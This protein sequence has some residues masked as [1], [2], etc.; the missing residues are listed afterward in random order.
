MVSELLFM[1]NCIL[2][3][4]F[5]ITI[6]KVYFSNFWYE[7]FGKVLKEDLKKISKIY[8]RLFFGKIFPIEKNC[9]KENQWLEY[10]EKALNVDTP[11]LCHH[12]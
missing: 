9:Q 5:S 8:N 6:V 7:N 12:R 3:I 1:M 2:C 4:N 11:C 10:F